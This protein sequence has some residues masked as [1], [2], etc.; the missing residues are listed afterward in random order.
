MPNQKKLPR[1]WVY[2]RV[3]GDCAAIRASY[4]ACCRQAGDDGCTVVGGSIDYKGHGPLRDGYQS[5]LRSIRDSKV[6][7]VYVSRMRQISGKERYLYAFFKCAMKHHVKVRTLEYSLPDRLQY[8]QAVTL[9]EGIYY[10]NAA[11]QYD[12]LN[13]WPLREVDGTTFLQIEAGG[14]Y[15]LQ[16]EFADE[17]WFTE[18]TGQTRYYTP[19]PL[20][21]PPADYLPEA[22]QISAYL[23]APAGFSQHCIVYLQNLYSGTV[24]ALD[25]Y[26]SNQLA[27]VCTEADSGLY[28]F[29]SARVAGDAA[30]RYQFECEQ[31][32][33]NTDDS[34]SFHLTVTDTKNPDAELCTPSRDENTAVQRAA[35]YNAPAA[36]VPSA[37][38][39]PEPTS[40]QLVQRSKKSVNPFWNVLDFLPIVFIGAGLFW[41]RRK[42]RRGGPKG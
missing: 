18:V 36:A 32:E 8:G 34:A 7:C 16:Y 24:Y 14:Q 40:S 30:E 5:M 11:V 3:P 39:T 20:R 6:N 26:E 12:A 29:L 21:R 13:D 2:A 27:A 23:T 17:S 15:E 4:D 19:L 42:N 41:F 33:L 31:K 37:T 38:Q 1:A 22:A 28:A 35:A 9:P 25:V 10:C